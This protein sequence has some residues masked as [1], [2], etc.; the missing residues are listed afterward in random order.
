M[1]CIG[2][3]NNVTE[4]FEC[5]LSKRM[6]RECLFNTF[7]Q[8]HFDYACSTWYLNL[9]KKFKTKLQTVH[10]CL[11]LH[12]RSH[13]GITEFKKINWFPADSRFRQCL[14]GNT[15]KVFDNRCPLYMKY[16]FNKYCISPASTKNFTIKTK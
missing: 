1:K 4:W 2:F 7:I 11:Q 12:K 13:V 14:A 10:F 16:V 8:P 6:S 9:N 3:S 5:Y 15:C